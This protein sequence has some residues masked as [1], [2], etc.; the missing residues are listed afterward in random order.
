M[1]D[2]YCKSAE[3]MRSQDSRYHLGLCMVVFFLDM[4]VV[5]SFSYQKRDTLLAKAERREENE[6]A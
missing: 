3:L 4:Q 6:V 2:F 1:L 5:L